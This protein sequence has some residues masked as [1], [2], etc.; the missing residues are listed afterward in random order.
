MS[1]SSTAAD[2][3]RTSGSSLHHHKLLLSTGSYPGSVCIRNC[4]RPTGADWYPE[5]GCAEN[6]IATRRTA[7]ANYHSTLKKIWNSSSLLIRQW[8]VFLTAFHKNGK[9][10]DIVTKAF[11]ESYFGKGM[12]SSFQYDTIFKY[13]FINKIFF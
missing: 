10:D 8:I 1:T 7:V 12:K 13:N 11:L 6:R 5:K 3:C 2:F 9:V 4:C